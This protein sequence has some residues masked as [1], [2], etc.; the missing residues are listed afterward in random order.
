MTR[1]TDG[2]STHKRGDWWVVGL[3]GF[4]AGAATAD[5]AEN[6]PERFRRPTAV[7]QGTGVGNWAGAGLGCWGLGRLGMRA[8]SSSPEKVEDGLGRGQDVEGHRQCQAFPEVGQVELGASKLPLHIRIVLGSEAEAM[9][10]LPWHLALLPAQSASCSPWSLCLSCSVQALPFP[11]SHLLL[12]FPPP[13]FSFPFFLPTVFHPLTSNSCP[14]CFQPQTQRHPSSFSLPMFPSTLP[15]CI[16]LPHHEVERAPDLCLEKRIALLKSLILEMKKMRPGKENL[17]QATKQNRNGARAGT[18]VSGLLASVSSPSL[19]PF[20]SL[21]S[22]SLSPCTSIFW[23]ELVIM[24]MS[25][26]SSTMTMTMVK[27]P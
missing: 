11:Q 2:L 25:M 23:K 18:Q 19:C 26:L 14:G 15:Q 8:L 21:A 12:I 1:T 6:S 20:F 24:A 13:G 4:A 5:E 17:P 27:M 10:G 7:G 3:L 16:L 22:G 9:Q